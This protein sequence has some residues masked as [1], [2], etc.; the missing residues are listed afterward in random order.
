MITQQIKEEGIY[1]FGGRLSNGEA[2]NKL[3]ILKLGQKPLKWIIP[4]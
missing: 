2:T 4:E 3:R 1:V